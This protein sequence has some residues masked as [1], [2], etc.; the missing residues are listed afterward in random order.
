MYSVIITNNRLT[1]KQRDVQTYEPFCM[2]WQF[3]FNIRMT[4]EEVCVCL[5]PACFLVLITPLGHCSVPTADCSPLGL[6]QQMLP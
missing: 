1:Y 4:S 5:S 6:C 2:K 3:P